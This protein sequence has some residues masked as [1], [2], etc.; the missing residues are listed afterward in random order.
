MIVF[1]VGS[2]FFYE[3]AGSIFF[4]FFGLKSFLTLIGS[5]EK[6]KIELDQSIKVIMVISRIFKCKVHYILYA[7]PGKLKLEATITETKKKPFVLE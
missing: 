2:V 3:Q 6:K 4:Y 1:F 7:E 5:R